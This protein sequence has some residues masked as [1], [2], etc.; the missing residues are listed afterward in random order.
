MKLDNSARMNFPG[1]SSG[2]W[3]WRFTSQMLTGEIQRRLVEITEL[4]G[5]LPQTAA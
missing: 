4:Y 1:K 5:R 2:Y 3:Q